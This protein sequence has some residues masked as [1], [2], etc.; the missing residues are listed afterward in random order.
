M[1]IE[2]LLLIA[3]Y[4]RILTW[5]DIKADWVLPSALGATFFALNIGNC[6]INETI[7]SLADN[8][9][10]LLGILVGFSIA[11]I[12][13]LITANTRNIEEIKKKDACK[14]NDSRV[15][16][17]FEVMVITY[18]YAVIISVFLIIFNLFLPSFGY[19]KGAYLLKA[20]VIASIDVLLILHILFV[21][22]RNVSN[23]YFI[24]IKK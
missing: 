8:A 10:S 13:L 4:F 17:L 3:D 24:L 12:T 14:I 11:V 19:N 16:S 7:K 20:N 9:I 21:T 22:I 15:V 18:S 5:R 2:F 23:F 1:N 6:D